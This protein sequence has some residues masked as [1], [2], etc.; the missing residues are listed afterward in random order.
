[1][2]RSDRSSER[3][4]EHQVTEKLIV[5]P[6][7]GPMV[8]SSKPEAEPSMVEFSRPSTEYPRAAAMPPAIAPQRPRQVAQPVK[9]SASKKQDLMSARLLR[10][11]C[12]QLSLSLFFRE[13]APVR[14]IG[15][16]STL[17][18]EGKTFM[19]RMMATVLADDS[20][21]PVAL[22]ECNWDHPT[23]H[24]YYGLPA[25]PGL[26][27]W[28]RG[29]CSEAAIRHQVSYNL[30]VIPAGSADQDVVRLLRQLRHEGLLQVLAA[31]NEFLVVDLPPIMTSGYGMLAAGLV[32]ALLLV[33]RAGVTP[34]NLIAETCEQLKDLP[35][36]GIVLNQ[37]KSHVPRWIRQMM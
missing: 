26:A 17:G 14:S 10:E 11:R 29:E 36:E 32:E 20:S 35:V 25:T 24:E 6:S 13:Q 2:N 18:G 15:F 22:V 21:E 5:P 7:T 8:T 33:V 37:V 27:E 30:T 9:K 31:P 23:L 4:I 28:L 3:S 16:T 34:N 19:A 1:M 12:R